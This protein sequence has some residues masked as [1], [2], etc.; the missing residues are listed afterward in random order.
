M[1]ITDINQHLKPPTGYELMNVY[2]QGVFLKI[3]Y[4]K[5]QD[6]DG[7]QI[8]IYLNDVGRE[9]ARTEERPHAPVSPSKAVAPPKPWWVSFAIRFFDFF[10]QNPFRRVLQCLKKQ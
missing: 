2:P 6:C 7:S 1:I 3:I 9:V 8:V 4:E 5:K 10:S